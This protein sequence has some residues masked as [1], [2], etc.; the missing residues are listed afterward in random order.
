MRATLP[1]VLHQIGHRTL[2]EHALRTAMQAGGSRQGLSNI[3][4]GISSDVSMFR[5]LPE[6]DQK[7][8]MDQAS[9]EERSRYQPFLKNNVTSQ[10]ADLVVEAQKA[11]NAGDQATAA[12]IEQK[13]R[14]LIQGAAKDGHITSRAAF[15]RSVG[16][17]IVARNAP[18][19]SAILSLPKRLRGQYLQQQQR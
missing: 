16:E 19:L 9:P 1:K 2:L 11:R 15:M 3:M 13:M 7:A 10:T 14:D 5:A 4:L 8:I 18:E 6:P 12:A 17:Q